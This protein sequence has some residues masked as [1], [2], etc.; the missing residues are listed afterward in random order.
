MK[1]CK[2]KKNE[3]KKK[4]GKKNKDDGSNKKKDD[5]LSADSISS[6]KAYL[7]EIHSGHQK[8]ILKPLSYDKK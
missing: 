8:K 6:I 4:D 1:A 7:S 5:E 2:R 3:K